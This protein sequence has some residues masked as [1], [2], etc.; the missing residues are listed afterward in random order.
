MKL[1][2]TSGDVIGFI[3]TGILAIVAVG[4]AIFSPAS[5]SAAPTGQTQSDMDRLRSLKGKDFEIQFMSMM[6]M[7]HSDAIAM[8]QFAGTNANHQEIKDA[9]QKIIA[10]QS[11]EITEM[12]DWLKAW[13][14]ATPI[15]NPMTPASGM[16][17]SDIANL[18]NMKGDDFDKQFMSMM[19][20][21]HTN[22][23]A[24][25]QTVP[26]RATHQ[27]LVTLSQNVISSQT[28]EKQE[29]SGWLM[30]WYNI[31]ASQLGN[32]PGGQPP[33]GP[34]PT[35]M[36]RTGGADSATFAAWLVLSLAL[37]GGLLMGGLLLRK[38]S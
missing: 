15:P 30:A 14:N 23:I 28:N 34:M 6:I 20:M 18:G 9:A 5:V 8:A 35:G 31:D 24:M 25:A 4:L 3:G 2:R 22:A 13:Y 11:Q 33:V 32:M 12:T 19:I 29:F 37:A 21:H 1:N 26:G 17:P 10:A 7:H 36:P 38:R 16:G 27:E